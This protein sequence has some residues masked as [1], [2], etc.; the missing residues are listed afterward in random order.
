MNKLSLIGNTL[1]FS[2]GLIIKSNKV[3]FD[4]LI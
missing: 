1:N 4:Y 3:G 2:N